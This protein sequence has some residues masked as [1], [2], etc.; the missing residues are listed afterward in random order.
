M[1]AISTRCAHCGQG[2]TL[3]KLEL[4][5]KQVSCPA[6]KKPFVV[7]PVASRKKSKPRPSKPAPADDFDEILDADIVEDDAAGAATGSDDDWLDALDGLP[8]EAPA[9]APGADAPPRVR[10]KKKSSAGASKK[11]RRLRDPDGEF[12]LW[13]HRVLMVG[14]GVVAGLVMTALWAGMISKSGGPSRYMAMLVGVMVGTAVRFGA[15]KWDF[16][17]GP[18]LT[19]S[20]IAFVSIFAGKISGYHLLKHQEN[21]AAEELRASELAMMQ[22]E[23]YPICEIALGM[24]EDLADAR[25]WLIRPSLKWQMEAMERFETAD[26]EIDWSEI[27]SPEHFPE[28]YSEVWDDAKKRW[29]EMPDAEKNKRRQAIAD[30][31]AY[32]ESGDSEDEEL[33]ELYDDYDTNIYG[34]KIITPWDFL[35]SIIAIVAA[36][37]IAAGMNDDDDDS[38]F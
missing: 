13:L 6:C 8:A 17:W 32:L 37:K 38:G 2:L 1:A 22:H 35:F 36:F 23:D 5:G 28:K 3:K 31:I 30:E 19:A 9:A 33:E 15:S 26:G 4:V 27:N 10:K 7:K 21:V 12:P 18:A 29:E 16:G 24:E 34:T 25:G 14:A 20:I 11:R